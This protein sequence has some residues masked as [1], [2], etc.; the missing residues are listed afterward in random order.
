VYIGASDIAFVSVPSSEE[1]LEELFEELLEEPLTRAFFVTVTLL[2]LEDLLL[3]D[4]EELEDFVV[5][6]FFEDE[7]L[8]F[9]LVALVAEVSG[10]VTFTVSVLPERE[11]DATLLDERSP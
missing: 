11:T 5:E 4:F 7:V 2:L 8:L 10:R 6:L 9:E 1:L 3:E